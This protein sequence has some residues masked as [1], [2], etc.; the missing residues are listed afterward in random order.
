MPVAKRIAFGKRAALNLFIAL[1][2]F[3]IVGWGLPSSRFRD[4]LVGWVQPYVIFTGIWHSWDMFSPD[5][6]IVNFNLYA[7]VVLADGQT[8]HW[9]FPRM[10]KLS[11]VERFQKERHRKWRE[12]IR[13]DAYNM[14]WR[15]TARYIA[16]ESLQ[17]GAPPKR[18]VLVREWDTITA[19]LDVSGQISTPKSSIPLRDYQPMPPNYPV[20]QSYRFHTY[21]PKPEDFP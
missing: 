20:T 10:E 16:R 8:N 12:R 9:E 21:Y 4:A 18:V 7:E 11:L 17:D 14:A 3:I 6:L 2:V 13:Q 19:P 15:D 1:H 5:P